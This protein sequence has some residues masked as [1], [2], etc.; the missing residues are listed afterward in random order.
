MK[1]EKL[2]K[3]FKKFLKKKLNNK[4]IAVTGSNGFISKHIIQE[5]KSLKIKNLKIKALNSQNTNYF[6][7]KNLNSKLKSV[8][9]VFHLSSATG[10]IKYTKENMSDQFYI[11]M[12]KDL[13]IFQSAKINN[14][15][16]LIT[17]G[18]LHAYPRNINKALKENNLHGKLPFA[19][20][21]GIGWSKRNLSV[22]GEIFIQNN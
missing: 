14:V 4:I 8:D 11:T 7:L 13:N 20:H 5:L 18:N 19:G 10:G 15:K 9:I 1:Q 2:Q 6:D 21:L 17:L 22:M 3:N 12:S 16:K